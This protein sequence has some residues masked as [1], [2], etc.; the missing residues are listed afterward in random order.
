M[1]WGSRCHQQHTDVTL[2][3]PTRIPANF[4]ENYTIT[5]FIREIKKPSMLLSRKPSTAFRPLLRYSG[6]WHFSLKGHTMK[7]L[8][9]RVFLKLCPGTF[10]LS[11]CET[12][13]TWPSIESQIETNAERTLV[14]PILLQR[15]ELTGQVPLRWWWPALTICRGFSFPTA[16]PE[17]KD[18]SAVVYLRGHIRTH[19]LH[20]AWVGG[21]SGQKGKTVSKGA[22][23]G[24]SQVGVQ[25]DEPLRLHTFGGGCIGTL[26]AA[27]W[28]FE[29]LHQSQQ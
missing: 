7:S 21:G 25:P 16:D 9:S 19:Q 20:R 13:F 10:P 26:R 5:K 8:W 6:K 14:F 11:H 29:T 23:Q 18:F 12:E 2:I 27:V 22:Y 15:Y 1:V 28:C 17:N 24:S 4:F 3:S